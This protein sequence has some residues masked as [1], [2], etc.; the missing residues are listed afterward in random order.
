METKCFALVKDFNSKGTIKED[1]QLMSNSDA[2][3][4]AFNEEFFQPEKN[5]RDR[6][7]NTYF[8]RWESHMIEQK[9][10]KIY[11]QFEIKDNIFDL[12]NWKEIK[13]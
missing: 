1:W 10:M 4:I 2:S 12:K 7:V 6:T 9:T 3:E 5:I 11:K 13:Q 8:T